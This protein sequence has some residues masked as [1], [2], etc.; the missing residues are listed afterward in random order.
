MTRLTRTI[1]ET[2]AMLGIGT[3]DVRSKLRDGILTPVATQAGKKLLVSLPS[4]LNY[5]GTPSSAVVDITM[6]IIDRN[7]EDDE[8]AP[9][10]PRG[11]G[12]PKR[13]N[14]R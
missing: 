6:D 11:P 2:A 7:L 8:D 12:R 5:L 1:E 13:R 14:A 10:I 3:R 9:R 4:I